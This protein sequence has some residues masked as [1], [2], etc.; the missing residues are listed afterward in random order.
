MHWQQRKSWGYKRRELRTSKGVTVLGSCEGCSWLSVWLHLALTKT[1]AAG[2]PC[3]GF[4]L[5]ESFEAGRPTLNMGLLRQRIIFNPGHTLWWQSSVKFTFST[6][7]TAYFFG[8][9]ICTEDWLEISNFINWTPS[10]FMDFPS[11]DSHCW[12]SWTT[13]CKP[14]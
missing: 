1:H 13:A 11:V 8:I 10:G 6:V 12:I 7:I 3:E 5:T 14:R 4:I 9:L 2:H